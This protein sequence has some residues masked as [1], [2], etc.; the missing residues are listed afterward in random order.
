MTKRML[1]LIVFALTISCSK[2]NDFV[3]DLTVRSAYS[4]NG[5]SGKVTLKYDSGSTNYLELG[6]LVNGKLH[7]V[8]NVPN[9]VASG[10]LHISITDHY[11]QNP[12]SGFIIKEISR[13]SGSVLVELN[14]IPDVE[15]AVK[16]SNCFD[17]TD[18]V[19]IQFLSAP[20]S[21]ARLYVGCVDEVSGDL[22]GYFTSHTFNFQSIS[23][24]NGV[25]D[26]LQHEFQAVPEVQN[27]FTIAY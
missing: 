7:V 12:F 23:K 6:K 11:Y 3:I 20:L 26:T 21:P 14:P 22:S 18:S 16:N 9:S 17:A 25:Y 13:Y 27:L 19:W 10:E 4:G 5:L 24:K 15:F 1:A 2:Q 8:A